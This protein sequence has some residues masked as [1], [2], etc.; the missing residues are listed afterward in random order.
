M[1]PF[2]G[3]TVR[4]EY[5]AGEHTLRIK[6]G[7]GLTVFRRVQAPLHR[8]L[9]QPTS[10]ARRSVIGVQAL[11][12]LIGGGLFDGSTTM[13]VGV[14]GVGKTVLGT[15]LLLE[16]ARKHDKRGLLLSL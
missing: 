13:V 5:V 7:K 1:A 3:A 9:A 4:Q 12:D 15:Q 16:G 14:S 11:D 10:T 8:D 2:S 6:G